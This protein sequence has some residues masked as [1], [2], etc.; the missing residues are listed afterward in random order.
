MASRTRKAFS[1]QKLALVIGIDEYKGCD[2]PLNHLKKNAED[3]CDQLGKM[4]FKVTPKMNTPG[5]I[6][7][8]IDDFME[9][10]EAADMILVYF[11][12]LSCHTEKKKGARRNH[13]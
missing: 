3:L 4:G 11:S 7:D 10:I 1:G 12:G 13:F 8:I 9:E 5:D 6:M 2:R